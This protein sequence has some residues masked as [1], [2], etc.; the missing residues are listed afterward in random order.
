[1]LTAPNPHAE[2]WDRKM[3]TDRIRQY[4]NALLKREPAIRICRI[5]TIAILGL[6][7]IWV[8]IMAPTGFFQDRMH[9]L[10]FPLVV[11]LIACSSLDASLRHIA[12]IKLYRKEIEESQPSSRLYQKG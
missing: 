2:R 10:T 8:L 5:L 12:S 7:L 4:D 1:M 6:F 3:K 11:L 9:I